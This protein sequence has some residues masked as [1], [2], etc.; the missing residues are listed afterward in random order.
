MISKIPKEVKQIA[1]GLKEHG[2]QAYLVGGSL[3]DI[4][5]K[6]EPK[7][8]DIATDAK[9][10]EILKLFPDSV[11]ENNFGTVGIKFRTRTKPD[12]NTDE[13]G[14]KHGRNRTGENMDEIGRES[15]QDTSASSPET[16]VMIIEVTTFRKDG[17][18]SDSRH[19]D[20]VVFA[21]SIEEDL[22]R[23]DFT[24]N[25][26]ALQIESLNIKVQND[27][28]KLKIVDPFDGQGDIKRKLIKA[29]GNPEERFAEDALRLMRAVRFAA[30]LDFDIE[31]STAEALSNKSNLLEFISQERIRDELEKMAMTPRAMEAIL[32]L[33]KFGLLKF[34]LPELRDGIGVGQN[35]HH[36][37][38]VFEHNIKALEYSASKNHSLEVRLASLLHD[39]GKPKSKRGEGPNCTFYGHQVVGE[40][41][42]QKIL[43]R[44]H[45]SNAVINK[46][47]LLV[48]E[49][50]FMYDPDIVTPA[51]VRRLL[52]RVGAENMEDLMRVREADRI[53]SGV[54]K[55]KTYRLRHLEAM[56]EKVKTDPVSAKMLKINGNDLM[57]E[58]K[59]SPSPKIGRIL[60]VLLEEV[61]DNPEINTK[62]EL[63]ARALELNKMTG[64][65]L[66]AIGMKA[67][68]SAAE[69]QERI[70]KDIEKRHYV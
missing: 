63:S 36:V 59:L 8:W 22:A 50:M 35:K 53:G 23:R 29:V 26:I 12:I 25:A 51:G 2:F 7:D 32:N 60:A 37:F 20:K 48:R 9:P 66:E 18:Y 31:K 44:L 14:Y 62:A 46:V 47:S 19:P 64:Q 4:L 68:K 15:V 21:K 3:R 49:H 52:R 57:A 24:C 27:S 33:E 38:T 10:E 45:F 30:Q 41:M 39:V 40:R 16:S 67:K 56:I 54:P 58:L 11:Y 55:A 5:M 43:T 28:S 42:A 17:K 61:L 69:A 6:R 34:I 1:T 13:T 65:E 70:D